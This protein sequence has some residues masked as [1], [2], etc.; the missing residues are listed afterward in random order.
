[1]I[2][3]EKISQEEIRNLLAERGKRGKFFEGAYHIFPNTTVPLSGEQVI[4]LALV[5]IGLSEKIDQLYSKK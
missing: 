1:M 2:Y 4:D 5:A 3:K